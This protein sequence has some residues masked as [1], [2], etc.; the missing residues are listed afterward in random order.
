MSI[1]RQAPELIGT[2][3]EQ[4]VLVGVSVAARLRDLLSEVT[5]EQ[6][7]RNSGKRNIEAVYTF[8]LP[9]NAELL[10]LEVELG[11]RQ[12]RGKAVKK[13]VAQERYEDAI[14]DGDA[15]VML[16]QTQPGIFTMNVGNLLP[17]ETCCIRFRY[18]ELL[19][20][21][22]DTLRFLLP[23]VIAPRY[24]N[25]W[26]AGV[27]PHAAPETDPSGDLRH[28]YALRVEVEGLLAGADITSPSHEVVVTRAG[29]R[30]VVVPK[31][32]CA[33]MDRDFVL[34]LKS[35]EAN[36]SAATCGPDRDG[37]VVLASFNPNL[38][39]VETAPHR[40]ASRLSWIAP[41]RWAAPKSA[42]PCWPRSGPAA[43]PTSRA[44]TSYLSPTARF[45]SRPRQSRSR[46]NP[47]TV[48]SRSGSATRLPRRSCAAW[49]NR[50]A[51]PASSLPRTNRWP[52]SSSATSTA[53][54]RREP[55]APPSSGPGNP[56]RSCPSG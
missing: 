20:W 26:R 37:Y 55:T 38:P 46:A 14:T 28:E 52:R 22:G 32:E 41:A 23:T 5:I 50:P 21:Q 8:P 56:T 7:Y 43:L 34:N 51:A 31:T 24:G 27:Q 53:S 33:V 40:T 49:P 25:A 45:G 16:E 13:S 44:A 11:E 17:G 3:Q 36:R 19:A 42:K 1:A 4:A 15:A 30:A 48:S 10:A 39:V 12:L 29:D 18:A 6:T 2:G 54:T 9:A 47:G 35:S